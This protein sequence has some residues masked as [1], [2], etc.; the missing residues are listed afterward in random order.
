M[1]PGNI[2][3]RGTNYL[4]EKICGTHSF[5]GDCRWGMQSLGKVSL[6][7]IPQRQV[8]GESPEMSL[9]NVVN[10]VVSTVTKNWMV[11]TF[12]VAFWN[13]KWLVQE[14]TA[15][16]Q[17]QTALGKDQSNPLIVGSL[18]KTTW[19]LIHHLLTDEVLTSPEQT[20]IDVAILGV[21]A[22]V[23]LLLFV[24]MIVVKKIM[25]AYFLDSCNF[26][27]RI[28]DFDDTPI[29]SAKLDRGGGVT[30]ALQ[31]RDAVATNLSFENLG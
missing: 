4:T 31:K 15:L 30:F 19:S 13:A 6:S 26:E 22:G 1:S 28:V 9:G 3:H 29:V 16:V 18:L 23:G 25:V 12:H 5:A 8:A 2:Y 21:H 14:G 20:A 7:S 27:S 24:V 10:V 17:E 11:F